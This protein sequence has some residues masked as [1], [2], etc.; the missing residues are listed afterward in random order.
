LEFEWHDAKAQANL[1]RHGITFESA[2]TVLKDAFGIERLDDRKDYG[3]ERFILMGVSESD[4]LLTVAYTERSGRI[5]II[6]APRATERE[7]NDYFR[8]Q[9]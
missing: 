1:R 8:Q 2:K 9:T 5:R 3:E 4:G 6:S 7:Q